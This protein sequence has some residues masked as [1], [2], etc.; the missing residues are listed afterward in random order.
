M[1]F[2]K[3]TRV[4]VFRQF[5]LFVNLVVQ[6]FFIG[7]ANSPLPYQSKEALPQKVNRT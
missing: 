2:S 1:C 3:I 5:L 7:Y 6:W 4:I